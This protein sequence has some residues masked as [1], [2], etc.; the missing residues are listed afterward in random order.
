LVKLSRGHGTRW[1]GHRLSEVHALIRDFALYIAILYNEWRSGERQDVFPSD[2]AKIKGFWLKM[3]TV[4][5]SLRLAAYENILLSC[6]T[7]LH[8]FSQI[9][10]SFIVFNFS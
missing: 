2:A 8:S 10:L 4:N 6:L 5:F 9:L 3:K 7:Y 1:V